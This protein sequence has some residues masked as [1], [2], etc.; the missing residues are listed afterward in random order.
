MADAIR[1]GDLPNFACHAGAEAER[2]SQDALGK[3]QEIAFDRHALDFMS[4]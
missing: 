2:R 4:G 3:R 1:Q